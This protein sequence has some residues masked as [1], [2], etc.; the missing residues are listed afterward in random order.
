MN[1]CSKNFLCTHTLSRLAE[2]YPTIGI[3]SCNLNAQLSSAKSYFKSLEKDLKCMTIHDV[4]NALKCLPN[5][6]SKVL[7][8]IDLILT[9]P[10]ISVEN[11]RFF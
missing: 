9:L 3:D 5:G 1:P 2:L 6:F 4:Q 7:K 8:I 10:V 11:E